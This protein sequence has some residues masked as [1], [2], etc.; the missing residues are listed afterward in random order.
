M[1]APDPRWPGTSAKLVT[2]V[3]SVPIG[4]V[5]PSGGVDPTT[6]GAERTSD[7]VATHDRISSWR[8]DLEGATYEG[9]SRVQDRL[10][11]LWGELGD[12]GTRLVEEWLTLTRHRSLFS[13]DELRGL[14]DELERL[15]A[16][17]A[18]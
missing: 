11:S 5:R 2:C 17:V 14:L 1:V 8:I 7:M 10:L 18:F 16:T 3:A 13:A 9:A 15:E 12:P 4:K 6:M